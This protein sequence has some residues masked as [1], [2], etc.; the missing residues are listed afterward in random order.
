MTSRRV[1]SWV[2]ILLLVSG[3]ATLVGAGISYAHSTGAVPRYS[4]PASRPSQLAFEVKQRAHP[5]RA[6]GDLAIRIRIPAIAVDAPVVETRFAKGMWQVA[7][8]A[9]GHLVGTASP[10]ALGNFAVAAHDDI[11]G[12]IFKRL[13]S[14]RNGDKVLVFTRKDE[15]VYEVAYS[16]VVSPYD[17][18]V[19]QPQA[20]HRAMTMITCTPYWVDS[21]REIVTAVLRKQIPA[22]LNHSGH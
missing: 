8:W 22:S 3:I 17:L 1:F 4:N 18:A 10:G 7:D 16:K 11:K 20:H 9:I 12:E 21:S 19:I 15:F 14:L 13:G 5:G 2:G 6:R